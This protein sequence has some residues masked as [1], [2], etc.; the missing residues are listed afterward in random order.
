MSQIA[1]LNGGRRLS[2]PAPF[3][4]GLLDQTGGG[5]RVATLAATPG[6]DLTLV[7]NSSAKFQKLT[8]HVGGNFV[9][10][11]AEALSEG[12]SYVITNIAGGSLAVNDDAAATIVTLP[13]LRQAT[14]ICDGTTWVH[15][16]IITV[17]AA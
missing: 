9:T 3:E 2:H 5:V 10:L 1:E 7:A 15:M 4:A 8:V 6:G 17:V 14:L 16:G 13:A 12:L 11:P